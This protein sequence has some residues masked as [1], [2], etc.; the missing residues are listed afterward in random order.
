MAR[1]PPARLRQQPQPASPR[2]KGVKTNTLS[3][4]AVNQLTAHKPL[5]KRLADSDDSDELVTR[6]NGRRRARAAQTVDVYSSGALGKGDV[7]NSH[8]TRAQR[9]KSLEQA[10]NSGKKPSKSPLGPNAREAHSGP[11]NISSPLQTSTALSRAPAVQPPSVARPTP[12]REDSILNGIKP[13]KR[14]NSILLEPSLDES[15]LGSFALP[16]DENSPLNLPR[17]KPLTQSPQTRTPAAGSSSKKR[18]LGADDVPTTPAESSRI[19]V[20]PPKE[21]TTEP[22]L[23]SVSR[24]TPAPADRK[25]LDVAPD[26]DETD[27]MAPPMSSS[28]EHSSPGR[29]PAAAPQRHKT[30]SKAPPVSLTTAD[31]QARLMPTK[32]QK[33]LRAR[34]KTSEFD[35]P[36][37]SPEDAEA[38]SNGEDDSTFLGPGKRRA[39]RA[40][41][42]PA[43]SAAPK[44]NAKATR[45]KVPGSKAK[46]S[47]KQS[48]TPETPLLSS[49]SRSL[50][51]P[52]QNETPA[53]SPSQ[54]S[55]ISVVTPP[56]RVPHGRRG[57][58]STGVRGRAGGSPLKQVHGK[59]NEGDD[60]GSVGDDEVK[61]P[62]PRKKYGGKW[63][64]I[65]DFEMDFEDVIVDISSD[66]LAR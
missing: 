13:R 26:H 44:K 49:P 60:D 29:P 58:K 19:P 22:R 43:A 37:D 42:Q 31:L 25:N 15:T 7:P 12:L 66:P 63:A 8:P 33:A 54:L 56:Q 34:N 35:I 18:K 27:I 61:L 38:Q 4:G 45:R 14:Q 10:L 1:R 64:E 59:E 51:Q 50:D 30:K 28:S 6:G 23:P 62:S 20:A 16:E 2:R 48:T 3:P 47:L 41:R 32:R 55:S 9:K 57:Y 5:G 52:D 17:Q 24:T 65:D 40:A 46:Q 36:S 39:T 21:H 11:T 53:K